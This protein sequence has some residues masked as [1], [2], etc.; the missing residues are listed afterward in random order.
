MPPDMQQVKMFVPVGSVEG[1]DSSA[2][3]EA[4]IVRAD[5]EK[6]YLGE[7]VIYED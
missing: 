4:R 6:N 3:E 7:A 2:A 5:R 1:I